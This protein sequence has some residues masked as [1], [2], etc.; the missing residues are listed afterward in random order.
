MSPGVSVPMNGAMPGLGRRRF[1]SAASA[2]G[3]LSLT[4][5]AIS[6]GVGELPKRSRVHAADDLSA[7]GRSGR[8]RQFASDA[9]GDDFPPHVRRIRGIDVIGWPC[10]LTLMPNVEHPK[11]TVFGKNR[12]SSPAFAGIHSGHPDSRRCQ[13]RGSSM[14]KIRQAQGARSS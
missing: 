12:T 14:R 4:K 9:L 13:C 1:T 8:Q 11:S 6:S 3:D 10:P 2:V 5:A 7:F